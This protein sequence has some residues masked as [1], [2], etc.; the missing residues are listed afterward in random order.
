M[1]LMHKAA[2]L[3]MTPTVARDARCDLRHCCVAAVE[4]GVLPAVDV[5]QGANIVGRAVAEHPIRP[6]GALQG[7]QRGRAARCLVVVRHVRQE[8]VGNL[9]FHKTPT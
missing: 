2:A 1:Q 4:R 9:C 6:Q 3:E 7:A 8:G 5:H